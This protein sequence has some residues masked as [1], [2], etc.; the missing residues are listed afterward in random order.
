H[1]EAVNS[2]TSIVSQAG[3]TLVGV[4]IGIEKGFQGAGDKLREQGVNLYSGAI[5]DKMTAKRITF[6]K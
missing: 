6:R 1:G 3:A 4:A 5:V 2:L